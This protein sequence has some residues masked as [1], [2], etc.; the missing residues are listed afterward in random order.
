MFS[1]FS[2]EWVALAGDTFRC[3]VVLR[4]LELFPRPA[5]LARWIEDLHQRKLSELRKKSTN[6]SRRE[7]RLR[8]SL[9]DAVACRQIPNANEQTGFT[10]GKSTK[11]DPRPRVLSSRRQ[12]G[13]TFRKIE[14][15][16]S[17]YE[18]GWGGQLIA[19]LDAW[20]WAGWIRLFHRPSPPNRFTLG[21]RRL[22]RIQTRNP[23]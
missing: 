2:I 23:K 16:T 5:P 11:G 6:N 15:P 21:I 22:S 17:H 10:R 8:T 3:C 18:S 4:V 14:R 12:N 20:I 13:T 9:A 7:P 1:S 19:L